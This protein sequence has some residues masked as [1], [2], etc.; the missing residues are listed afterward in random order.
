MIY[1]FIFL[2]FL[3]LSTSC[4][5][6][7]PL[8]EPKALN[9]GYKVYQ[10]AYEAFE[11]SDFFYAQKNSLRQNLVLKQLNMLLNLQ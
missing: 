3:I 9:D 10:E 5:K 6:E 4:S 7:K 1:R 2:S 11:N 8:Y